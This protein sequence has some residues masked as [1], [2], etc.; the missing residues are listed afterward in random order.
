MVQAGAIKLTAGQDSSKLL[1]SL[2]DAGAII[3]VSTVLGVT[4]GRM[5]VGD[6][7]L[8]VSPN[9]IGSGRKQRHASL[10][11]SRLRLMQSIMAPSLIVPCWLSALAI[12]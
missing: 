4:H 12:G 8:A 2:K 10:R 11:G 3:V 9:N 1:S 7:T 6:G 5:C